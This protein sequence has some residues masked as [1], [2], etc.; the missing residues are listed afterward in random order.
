[1]SRHLHTV[2]THVA[3][4]SKEE[5]LSMMCNYFK[6]VCVSPNESVDDIFALIPITRHV[7]M[8]CIKC[9]FYF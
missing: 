1:M 3:S 7:L 6:Q 9:T 2:C 5:M 4:K 8:K